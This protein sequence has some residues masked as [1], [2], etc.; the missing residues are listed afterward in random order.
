MSNNYQDTRRAGKLLKTLSSR[1]EN[2]RLI[3]C[4]EHN[5]RSRI[6]ALLSHLAQGHS[7][8]FVS[9]A[10]TPCVSDPGAE[11]ISAAIH[12]GAKIVPLPG[13]CA[14]IA[15]LVAS[16][17]PVSGFTFI[18][19]LPRAGSARRL[20]FDQLAGNAGTVILYEAPHRLVSTLK[21]LSEMK[22]EKRA[23]CLGRELTK[24]WEE[25]LRF[26]NAAQAY[27]FYQQE[28]VE[29]RGEFTIVIAPLTAIKPNRDDITAYSKADVDLPELIRRLVDNDV[30]VSTIARCISAVSDAPKKLVYAYAIELN[31]KLR[32]DKIT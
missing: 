15:A 11:L 13:A 31:Q 32:A 27:Q 24:K 12:A 21:A 29:P 23:I 30:P 20:A 17:M 14:A 16:G 1:P 3:S 19:F 5:W 26:D 18:G 25:F 2:Q 28:G 10:G 9:D 6:P 22:D 4:H 7:V 8:A